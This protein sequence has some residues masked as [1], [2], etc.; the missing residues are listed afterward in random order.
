MEYEN[1][2]SPNAQ[3]QLEYDFP[4]I[5]CQQIVS[6]LGFE[7][8]TS[9]CDGNAAFFCSGWTIRHSSA[10]QQSSKVAAVTEDKILVSVERG[11]LV[12]FAQLHTSMVS[13][14]D[15]S[16]NWETMLS[17]TLPTGNNSPEG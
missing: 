16:S 10:K 3:S 9:S 4:D 5:K 11:T 8:L 2:Q 15:V 12:H 7:L 6:I 14:I 1:A 13:Q 17:P